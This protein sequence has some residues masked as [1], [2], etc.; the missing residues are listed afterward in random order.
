[1][2]DEEKTFAEKGYYST[3]LKLH[4]NKPVWALCE[5]E[6]CQREGGRG[7]WVKFQQ[8]SKLCISCAHKT[9]EYRR[10]RRE[11]AK[12]ENL[13]DETMRKRI[14]AAKNLS[15]DVLQR[16]S[17]TQKRKTGENSPNWQGGISF[18]K[19]CPKFNKE[20]KQNIRDMYDN[21][22]YISG[23]SY[24]LCNNNIMLD[25]HHV[26]YNKL[27]GCDDHKWR[28][29]PLSKRN[30]T[31]TNSNRSFWNR[32][33]TYSLQHDEKYY[34]EEDKN[35]DVFSYINEYNINTII[36]IN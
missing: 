29:I 14:Y 11:I 7:R 2:I 20:T 5:G 23:I 16:R 17:D 26:D 34:K 25:V 32:I 28:L 24:T 12:R 22:D 6:D 36:G 3:D 35:F 13:S 4:S 33:F 19:Y 9:E 10:K 1:M 27:Q 31:R 18:G 15:K 30:H 21:C 8:Y